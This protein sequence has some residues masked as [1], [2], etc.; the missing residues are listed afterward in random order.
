VISATLA[1]L[2]PAMAG[3]D[4]CAETLRWIAVIVP[5]PETIVL[6]GA[7]LVGFGAYGVYKRKKRSER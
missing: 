2:G 5:E 6:L 7:V 4:V 3:A 1:I